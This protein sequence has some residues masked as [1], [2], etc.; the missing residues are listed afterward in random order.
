MLSHLAGL[1]GVVIAVLGAFAMSFARQ[2]PSPVPTSAQRPGTCHLA[3]DP[4]E[5]IAIPSDTAP[6]VPCG[7]PHQTETMFLSRLTGPLAASKTRPNGELLNQSISG[8]CYDYRRVR[9]Y[10]GAGPNDVTWGILSWARFPTAADWARG[11]RTLVCQGSSQTDSPTGPTIDFSLDGVMATPRSA[12]FRL[13]RTAAVKNVT[14]DRPHVK[15]LT[16]P[17][18]TLP[19]GPWPG[20]AVVMTMAVKA[21]TPV[22]GAYLGGSISTRPEL[23]VQPDAPRVGDWETGKRSAQCWIANT[24][25]ASTTGTVRGTAGGPK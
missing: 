2:V 16:S 9:S 12:R 23:V 11:D 3:E 8:Q 7:Q 13:C 14:C 19:P 5:L 21:C 1:A 10:L 25:G 4:N 22:I 15:E 6:P 24:G 18:A 20:D 17:D